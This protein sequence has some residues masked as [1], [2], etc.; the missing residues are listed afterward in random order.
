MRQPRISCRIGFFR[1]FLRAVFVFV[2]LVC[3]S[4]ARAD[5]ITLTVHSDDAELTVKAL[6]NAS[7]T[8][9]QALAIA[10]MHGNQGAIRK[11]HEYGFNATTEAFANALYAAAHNQSVSDPVERS[12]YFDQMKAKAPKLAALLHEINSNPQEFRE[13]IERRAALFT[14]QGSS[15]HIDGYIIAVGDGGGYAFDEPEFFLNIGW[16]ADFAAAKETMTHEFYHAIQN[17]LKVDWHSTKKATNGST[18]LPCE[19]IEQLIAD[20]YNEGSAM[21]ADDQSLNAQSHSVASERQRTDMKDGLNHIQDSVTLLDLSIIGIQAS[22]P[23]PYDDIYKL[24]FFG[25]GILYT[26]GYV[27][28]K[29]IVEQDGPQGLAAFLKRPPYEFA[30]RYTKLTKYG[31]DHEHPRLGSHAIAAINLIAK[32]C[33]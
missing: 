6:Q 12:F 21:Y 20:V 8:H 4:M 18:D 26:L 3:T 23:V 22:P 7:L 29:G 19:H 25:H 2:P 14:P 16:E 30:L 32:G 10:Q 31:L 33:Q 28:A 1:L 5:G 11:D 15:G 9:E 24:D 13:A 27:M 17:A